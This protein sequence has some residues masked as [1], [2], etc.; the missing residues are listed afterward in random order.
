VTAF[1]KTD[2]AFSLVKASGPREL[3]QQQ[4]NFPERAL[5]KLSKH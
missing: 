3:L 1:A 4:F 2:F 5:I